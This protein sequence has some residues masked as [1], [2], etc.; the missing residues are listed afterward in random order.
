MFLRTLNVMSEGDRNRDVLHRSRDASV[1]AVRDCSGRRAKDE[2]TSS[3][4]KSADGRFCFRPIARDT[5]SFRREQ[6]FS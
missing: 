2:P 6:N 1:H 5:P 4:K 3:S